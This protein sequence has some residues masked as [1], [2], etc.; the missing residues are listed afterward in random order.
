MCLLLLGGGISI[1]CF[2]EDSLCYI[3]VCQIEVPLYSSLRLQ[4]NFLFTPDFKGE[5]NFLSLKDKTER[6]TDVVHVDLCIVN[7]SLYL[8]F[9]LADATLLHQ[10]VCTTC[11][12]FQSHQERCPY[13][14]VQCPSINCTVK[15]ARNL[16]EEHLAT[17]CLWK[18]VT[19][20]FCNDTHP[21]SQ[22]DVRN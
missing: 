1:L 2:A 20:Q 14:I 8:L 19:C 13:K 10:H 3:E 15:L 21:K 16:I 6:V 17:A 4:E 5:Q 7:A 11:I 9:R 22:E 12:A 18:I